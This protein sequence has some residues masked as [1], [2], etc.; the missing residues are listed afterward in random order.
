LLRLTGFCMALGCPDM[1]MVQ[2]NEAGVTVPPVGVSGESFA[3]GSTYASSDGSWTPSLEEDALSSKA[4]Y[5][6]PSLALS[7]NT[8][9]SCIVERDPSLDEFLP[10]RRVRSWPTLPAPIQENWCHEE[11][12]AEPLHEIQPTPTDEEPHNLFSG[13][14]I[15]TPEI[16]TVGSL[17]HTTFRCKPCAFILK[18]C[19]SGVE[20]QFCHLCDPDE[21][22]R[23]KREKLMFRRNMGRAPN[24]K[25][26]G[27]WS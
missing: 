9:L 19:Q 12:V 21:R 25:A 10:V 18:G 8:F 15:G 4:S 13:Q 14:L 24:R 1:A 2:G 20:C 11:Q 16:P 7:C 27:R 5:V 23:R 3:S 6:V 22:K 17:Q 26:P